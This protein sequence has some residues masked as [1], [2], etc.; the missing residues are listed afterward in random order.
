[1]A[2]LELAEAA[3]TVRRFDESVPPGREDLREMIRAA[4]LAPCAANLQRLRFSIVT[5]ERERERLFRGLGWA[6][7]LEDWHG[8]EKGR[9]PS[10]YIIISSP[11]GDE[12]PFTKTDAGIAAA[13]IA[14]AA[15]D[16]GYG[17]CMML[18]FSRDDV[19][20][21]ACTPGLLPELVLALG[22]PAETVV[23][24]EYA[25]SIRYYRDSLGRHHVPKMTPT[26]LTA[27]EI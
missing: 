4:S 14:L 15:R 17:C 10:A 27:K 1:M 9:R 20:E 11:A 16:M 3:R 24:D 2:F 12:K 22:V 18:S 21:I 13:Y 7:Y 5:G 25:G 19:T 6:G 26:E 23:L 8:P